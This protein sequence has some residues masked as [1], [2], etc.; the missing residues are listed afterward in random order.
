MSNDHKITK[1]AIE[2]LRGLGRPIAYH[3]QIARIFGKTSIGIFIS[4]F[5]YWSDKGSKDNGWIYKS[6]EEIE[7]ETGISY[8]SQVSIRRRLKALEILKEK[9]V[10]ISGRGTPLCFKFDWEKLSFWLNGKNSPFLPVRTRQKFQYELDKS[11]SSYNVTESTTENT[12]DIYSIDESFTSKNKLNTDSEVDI[13]SQL[14]ALVNKKNRNVE[15]SENSNIETSINSS[16]TVSPE[17]KETAH[18]HAP[19]IETPEQFD[20]FPRV[21]KD[22]ASAKHFIQRLAY[23][24]MFARANEHPGYVYKTEEAY[25][26]E[27]KK[28]LRA[29]KAIHEHMVGVL[30][31]HD[32]EGIVTELFNWFI[33][34]KTFQDLQVH[35]LWKYSRK[36]HWTLWSLRDFLIDGDWFM[37][38]EMQQYL[39][40]KKKVVENE[41]A[42][43]PDTEN[44]LTKMLEDSFNK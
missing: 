7:E 18:A 10:Q 11:S 42:I 44:D 6:Q 9:R 19:A 24:Y 38:P 16:P 20:F 22:K 40:T 41:C 2:A 29:S 30:A 13:P 3:P 14:S 23:T 37:W 5:L 17:V 27:F 4:Q 43:I 36:G 34:G 28:N 33:S 1:D 26:T 39:S 25:L 31:D 15:T 12:T 32:A 21:E 8:K 35:D